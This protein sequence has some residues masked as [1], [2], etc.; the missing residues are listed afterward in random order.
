MCTGSIGGATRDPP[1]ARAT[2]LTTPRLFRIMVVQMLASVYS[3][4]AL[5]RTS[6]SFFPTFLFLR[7]IVVLCIL[8]VFDSATPHWEA[9]SVLT[10]YSPAHQPKRALVHLTAAMVAGL[11][12]DLS[13]WLCVSTVLLW[14]FLRAERKDGPSDLSLYRDRRCIDSRESGVNWPPAQAVLCCGVS[15][16]RS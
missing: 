9:V 12:L 13:A 5:S 15:L 16:P 7:A 1:I 14:R 6:R 3:S 8:I 11:A 4:S 2:S 10:R